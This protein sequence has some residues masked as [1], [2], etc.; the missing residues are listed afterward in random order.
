MLN[1]SKASIVRQPGKERVAQG[2]GPIAQG[3]PAEDLETMNAM[4]QIRERHALE[5]QMEET[6]LQTQAGT[7]PE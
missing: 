1:R 2:G 6:R 4:A 5:L 3:G 7:S